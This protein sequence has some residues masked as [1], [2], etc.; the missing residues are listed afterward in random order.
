MVT[1]T[2]VGNVWST[3]RL[4]EI[5]NGAFLEVQ[6]EGSRQ[7]PCRIRRPR[8]R[9]RRTGARRPGLGRRGLVPGQGAA[10]RRLD[11]RI[12]RRGRRPAPRR[13]P[14]QKRGA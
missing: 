10:D 14:A 7:P 6:L 9:D 12:D 8:K 5:P 11:R 3:R 4:K 13:A 1:A 2:V